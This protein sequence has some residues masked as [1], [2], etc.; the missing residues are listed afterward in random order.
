MKSPLTT[1]AHAALRARMARNVEVDRRTN[2][3][4][5]ADG[6]DRTMVRNGFRR[7]WINAGGGRGEATEGTATEVARPGNQAQQG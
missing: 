4:P 3:H 1:K 5:S 2:A 6:A 7:M